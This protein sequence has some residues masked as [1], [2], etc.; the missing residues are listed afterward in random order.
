MDNHVLS[1]ANVS[2]EFEPVHGAVVRCA[3][4]GLG[5]DLVAEQR[6]A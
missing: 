6:L 1:N 3:H 4:Q 5:I 2:V